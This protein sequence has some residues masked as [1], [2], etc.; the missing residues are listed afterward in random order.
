MNYID[1]IHTKCDVLCYLV[2]F[3]QFN[4]REKDPWKSDATTTLLKISP[5]MGVFNDF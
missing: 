4:K 5:S 3:L 1:V 2:P